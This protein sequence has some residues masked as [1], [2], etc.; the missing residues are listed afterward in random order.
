[1]VNLLSPMLAQKKKILKQQ[2]AEISEIEKDKFAV[3]S[4]PAKTGSLNSRIFYEVQNIFRK[5]LDTND[6]N[7][8]ILTLWVISTYFHNQFTAFP[9]LQLLAQKRAGKTRTLK[10]VSSLSCNGDGSVMTSPTETLLFRNVNRPL[11]F[12]EMETIS[13]KERG[14]FRETLNACY[15][16]GNKIIRYHEV[17][18]NG[19]KTF[20]EEIFSPYYPVGLANI[21]G[22]GDVLAD[23]AIQV[24]LMRS[25]SRITQLVE[26]FSNND[27]ISAVKKHLENLN[28]KIPEGLF[29]EWNRFILDEE[30]SSSEMKDFFVRVRSAG[31]YGRP[32]ELFFPLFFIAHRC[33]VIDSFLQT[34]RKYVDSKEFEESQNI[35]EQLKAFVAERNGALTDFVSISLLLSEFRM[36]LENPENWIN[37]R[38]F[39]RALKRLG[40]ILKQRVVNG[41]SQVLLNINPTNTTNPINPINTTNP[42]KE[43]KEV[44]FVGK[45]GFSGL[46]GNET[47]LPSSKGALQ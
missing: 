7:F 37:S 14:A 13:S 44:V 35:D 28:S 2:L 30:I 31:I 46:V 18:R 45:V 1:M 16:K 33:G 41:R 5:Y 19:Q 22:L 15:K 24:V 3:V 21:N 32:L 42:T 40:L 11:F 29:S 8:Q 4:L 47:T 27:E 23:R 26:D 34:A 39:G 43:E 25:S 10:L 12:D 6:E 38:W 9:L 17:S 36:S 20:E